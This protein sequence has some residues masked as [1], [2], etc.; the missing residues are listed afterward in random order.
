[1]TWQWYYANTWIECTPE[2]QS[3]LSKREQE[4]SV[5]PVRLSNDVGEISGHPENDHMHFRMFG[6]DQDVR[7][8][9]R[10]GPKSGEAPIYA[11]I[12]RSLRTFLPYEAG[13]KLFRNGKPYCVRKE[14]SVGTE[15]YVAE[16]G[17]LFKMIEGELAPV[18]WKRTDLSRT[19][20]HNITSTR[21]KWEFK[22]AFRLERIRAAVVKISEQWEDSEAAQTLTDAFEQFDPN[23]DVTEHGPYQFNDFL[24][25]RGLHELAISV[26][27]TY[28]A[29]APTEWLSF[30]AIT[31]AQIETARAEGRPIAN[32][33]VRDHQYVIIFDSGSGASGQ[34]PVVIRPLRYE[35]ILTSIEEN[36]GRS[37]LKLL[38]DAL[39]E[40]GCNPRMFLMAAMTDENSIDEFIPEEHRERIRALLR[41]GSIGTALQNQL[42]PLLEKYKECEIRLSSQETLKPK[43]L[44]SSIQETL[45]T[46]FC[47]PEQL[48]AYC[49]TFENMVHHIRD[50]Q[51]WLLGSGQQTCDLCAV[52]GV[53]LNH[54]GSSKA[55]L[56]CWVDSLHS[57]SMRCPFCRQEVD[58]AQLTVVTDKPKRKK[59]PG[60]KRKRERSF[61]T[62]EEVLQEIH[63]DSLYAHFKL[64]DN[65]SMRKW[66]TVLMRRGMLKNGQLP[67][68]M[69]AKKSLRSA[70]QEFNILN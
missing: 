40:F 66:F 20:L 46:G 42:P 60:K 28:H 35:R 26:M 29:D 67:R 8:F 13:R 18:H 33:M 7:T 59:M 17:H 47:V 61:S 34:P 22:G 62:A 1:M 4:P 56:K 37:Q 70:L 11:V 14:V 12:Q 53:V 63:K 30:D 32:I 25:A 5:E 16:K 65:Q 48:Q 44:E 3:K 43:P 36:Y 64:E 38:Y 6:D 19:Q 2:N 55:C 39:H 58:D 52:K 49:P 15:H 31:N 24:V 23:F 27:E 45:V 41:G 50:N 57:D 54:C 69:Q 9:V 10:K 21:Y 68:N 51:C